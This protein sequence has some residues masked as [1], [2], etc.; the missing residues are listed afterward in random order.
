MRRNPILPAIKPAATSR[1]A[2]MSFAGKAVAAIGFA[3]F[4]A[5][6]LGYKE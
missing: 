2:A 4:I 5:S 1:A 6:F 3:F